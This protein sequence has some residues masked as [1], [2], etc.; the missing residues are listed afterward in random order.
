MAGITP[1][2]EMTRLL[3]STGLIM[4]DDQVNFLVDAVVYEVLHRMIAL[5]QQKGVILDGHPNTDDALKVVPG[6]GA[7][8]FK[9]KAGTAIDNKGQ[10]IFQEGDTGD[11]A[12]PP[13]STERNVLVEWTYTD[14]TDGTF[15]SGY[16]QAE[17]TETHR[18]GAPNYVH[19]TD[20]PTL[21]QIKLGTTWYDGGDLVLTDNR[22]N[23]MFNARSPERLIA[24]DGKD[25]LYL[26]IRS[27]LEIA[28]VDNNG[29]GIVWEEVGTSTRP[30]AIQGYRVFTGEGSPNGEIDV[31]FPGGFTFN[32]PSFVLCCPAG[33]ASTGNKNWGDNVTDNYFF[34]VYPYTPT[35]AG[36]KMVFRGKDGASLITDVE[37]F[38]SY[39]AI[40][41]D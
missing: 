27:L 12:V 18:H 41:L 6:S 23:V 16:P 11:T 19:T 39:I 29:S 32:S 9:V 35:T 22:K 33:T 15:K 1:P 28:G 5:T 2:G 17:P 8:N 36:F 10:L 21:S 24:R 14:D 37:H 20:A 38:G 26:R 13:D 7:G 34:D 31:T 40:G 30:A 4:D 3:T 25:S